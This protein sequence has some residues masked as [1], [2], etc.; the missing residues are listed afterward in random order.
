[1][2][3]LKILPARSGSKGRFNKSIK[4]LCGKFI[5]KIDYFDVQYEE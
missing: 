2:S 5:D 1:M 4:N 3:S